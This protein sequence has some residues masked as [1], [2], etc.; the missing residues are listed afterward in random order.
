[1]LRVKGP[2]KFSRQHL[3]MGC[4]RWSLPLYAF[5]MW[6]QALPFQSPMYNAHSNIAGNITGTWDTLHEPSRLSYKDP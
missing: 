6:Y 3:K 2:L 5:G 4:D 1:M